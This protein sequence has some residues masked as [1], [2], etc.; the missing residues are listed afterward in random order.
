MTSPT[1]QNTDFSRDILG[2]FTCNGLDEALQSTNNAVRPDARPF[3]VIVIGGGSFAGV[4]AQHLFAADIARQHRVLVL[5]AGRIAVPE[6]VQN[7]PVLGLNPPPPTTTDPGVARAEVWGLP[8]RTNVAGGFP[9]LAYCLGGR[10]IYFGGWSPR[11]LSSELPAAS[12]PAAMIADLTAAKGYFDQAA[13]QIGTSSTNDFISGVMHAAMRDQLKNGIDG[14]AVTDAIALA[15]LPIHQDDVP[16]GQENLFKL[17]APLAVQ[18]RAPR[19]GFF[20]FNKFSSVP[21]FIEA[22]RQA[23]AEATGDDFKK[24]LMVVPGCH[25][26]RLITDGSSNPRRVVG[27]DTDQGLIPVPQN[28]VVVLA[29][30]TIE[31]A[32]LAMFS[33]PGLPSTP[34]MGA[35]LMAHL[36]SNLTIRI[37]RGSI[38][39]LPAA[40]KELQASA[41]FV[42]GHRDY[43]PRHRRTAAG[44][45]EYAGHSQRRARRIQYAAC[46]RQHP[47][48]RG[49]QRTVGRH[50]HCV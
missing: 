7:L 40:V 5:E 24:R 26:I 49:G 16:A 27:V 11:L 12:W 6:H 32:R 9:G 44:Q 45:P 29:T 38:A 41:L 33:L 22:A 39:G 50:G 3:D 17:E 30:G 28:G 13:E 23:Q 4:L 31:S 14:A 18:S 34:R 43:H 20:P 47:A 15:S 36:R 21:L 8:W 42:K 10:S 48:Q 46:F 37:P 1:A 35:N 2:R 25:V 19:S